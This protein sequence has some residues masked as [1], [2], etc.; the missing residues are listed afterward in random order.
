M[1]TGDF[2]MTATIEAGRR[3]RKEWA[4]AI[5]ALNAVYAVPA[6]AIAT[7]PDVTEAQ[8]AAFE[9]DFNKFLA[10]Q[11][12]LQESAMARALMGENVY[13]KIGTEGTLSEIPA[14]EVEMWHQSMVEHF[15]GCLC[16]RCIGI[17]AAN[18]IVAANMEGSDADH[19]IATERKTVAG[20][21]ADIL[22]D[23]QFGKC[24]RS[25]AVEVGR[26]AE[27]AIADHDVSR[28]IGKL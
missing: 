4:D 26:A 11:R 16:E 2:D 6:R 10:Q 1:A 3:S 27:R 24:T 19:P 17:R 22:S 13:L 12:D 28:S 7:S 21:V 25:E 5:S 15:P 23:L 8:R 14:C 20:H 9:A 18:P